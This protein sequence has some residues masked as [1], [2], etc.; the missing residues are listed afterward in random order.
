MSPVGVMKMSPWPTAPFGVRKVTGGGALGVVAPLATK[1]ESASP[2]AP[3]SPTAPVTAL[4]R[5]L[6]KEGRDASGD[7][8]VDIAF[9]FLAEGGS[10]AADRRRPAALVPSVTGE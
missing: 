4:R 3:A 2:S 9:P 8:W 10:S 5:R 6:R 7:A 1:P